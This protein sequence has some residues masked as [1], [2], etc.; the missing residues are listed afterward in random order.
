MDKF[1]LL[2]LI[3]GLA[4]LAY[5]AYSYFTGPPSK[6]AQWELFSRNFYPMQNWSGCDTGWGGDAGGAGRWNY[7]NTMLPMSNE[8]PLWTTLVSSLKD[9]KPAE[10]SFIP[11]ILTQWKTWL[12]SLIIW[13]QR[14][15]NNM[16]LDPS[17]IEHHIAQ[18]T[19][20]LNW[21]IEQ[22]RNLV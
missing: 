1:L 5:L 17:N 15:L 18:L 21:A 2:G 16:L 9:K 7:I 8:M 22:R 10:I 4:V 13:S 3:A 20:V 6:L 11:E 12:S 14:I 19:S